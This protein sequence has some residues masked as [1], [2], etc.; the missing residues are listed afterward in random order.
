M[1]ACILFTIFDFVQGDDQAAATHLSGGI[2]LL[3]KFASNR[4][5]LS[6]TVTFRGQIDE[7]DQQRPVPR[8]SNSGILQ[9]DLVKV[10][11]YLDFWAMMWSDGETL[12]PEVTL[13]GGLPVEPVSNSRKE[14]HS[15][16][17]CFLPL[18]H[19]IHE[20]LRAAKAS[21][22]DGRDDTLTASFSK[23]KQDLLNR[24]CAWHCELSALCEAE[25]DMC[26]DIQKERVSITELNHQKVLVMLQACQENGSS[27]YRAFDSTFQHIVST[28]RSMIKGTVLPRARSQVFSFAPRLIHPLYITAMQCCR[29][30][31]CREAIELLESARWVEGAWNSTIMARVARRKLDE[32]HAFDRV[33]MA[34]L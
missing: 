8:I 33:D 11:A 15:H 29:V 16:L 19:R 31:V 10:F 22:Y 7:L 18:E 3:R 23:T 6:H 21:S 5:L 32:R 24:L 30:D 4:E 14:L 1:L 20:F 34:H 26:D 28:S 27:D 9:R 13:I 25:Y 2:V 12:L 17:Q